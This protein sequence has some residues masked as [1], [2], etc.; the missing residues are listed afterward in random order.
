MRKCRIYK[1]KAKNNFFLFLIVDTFFV[2]LYIDMEPNKQ[3]LY[4]VFL[5]DWS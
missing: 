4:V 1:S 5:Q 2:T 3:P